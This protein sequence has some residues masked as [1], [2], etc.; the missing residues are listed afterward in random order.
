MFE[1]L[2]TEWHFG[3][4]IG[5]L[6]ALYIELTIRSVVERKFVLSGRSGELLYD[7][8]ITY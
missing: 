3:A 5:R 8:V 1:A 6:A 7:Y 2:E 4:G